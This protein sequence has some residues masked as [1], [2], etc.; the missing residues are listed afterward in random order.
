[1]GD[2]KSDE[3]EQASPTERMADAHGQAALLLVE[4]LIHSLIVR[5]VISVPEAIEI[6]EV[7]LD[8]DVEIGADLGEPSSQLSQSHSLLAAISASLLVDRGA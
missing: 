3:N 1:M 2:M 8:V 7:A 4:S 6:V 5:S